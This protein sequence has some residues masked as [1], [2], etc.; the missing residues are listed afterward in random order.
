MDSKKF[1]AGITLLP[2]SEGALVTGGYVY[3]IATHQ[4]MYRSVSCRFATPA[5]CAAKEF[6]CP[7][8]LLQK[9]RRCGY[10]SRGK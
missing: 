8:V 2:C 1:F 9:G 6:Q 10:P 4:I 5:R 7:K 3:Q